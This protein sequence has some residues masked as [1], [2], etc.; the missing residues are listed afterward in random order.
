MT[1]NNAIFSGLL[2]TLFLMSGMELDAKIKIF[3]LVEKIKQSDIILIGNVKEVHEGYVRMDVKEMLKGTVPL[4]E[5]DVAWDSVPRMEKI[6]APY[7]VGAQFLLFTSTT[8]A[9][10]ETFMGGQGAIKLEKNE[11]EQYKGAVDLISKY[12]VAKSTEEIKSRLIAMLRSNNPLLQQAALLDFI[13]LDAGKIRNV[14][15]GE[16]ELAQDIIRL[17]K[18]SDKRVVSNAIYALKRVGGKESIPRLI[19]LVGDDDESIAQ[20]AARS[21]SNKTGFQ[22]TIERGRSHAERKK[23]QAEWQDWWGK[24]KDKVK[25]RR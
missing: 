11:S 1:K 2:V 12:E 3:S 9:R 23:I 13:Y 4:K 5:I 25:I 16:K 21:L 19:E 22:K 6:V 24:N 7:S 17:T 10:Y 15:I 20:V 8:E 14:G 18:D